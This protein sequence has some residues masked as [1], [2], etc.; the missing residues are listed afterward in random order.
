MTFKSLARWLLCLPF[1]MKLCLS[2]TLMSGLSTTVSLPLYIDFE[3]RLSC[4]GSVLVLSRLI[5]CF[6]S[7]ICSD[8]LL[9]FI[10]GIVFCIVFLPI[11]ETFKR[12]FRSAS[13][14]SSSPSLICRNSRAPDS[15]MYSS[16]V[17]RLEFRAYIKPVR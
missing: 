5:P 7:L 13:A 16:R 11:V 10:A 3:N 2:E 6:R 14:T 12:S 1:S 4:M 8:P 15:L 17:I 9:R